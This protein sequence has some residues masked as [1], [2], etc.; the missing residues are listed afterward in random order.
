MC[1]CVC[2]APL[3]TTLRALGGRGQSHVILL[4]GAP[5]GSLGVLN[6][7]LFTEWTAE[8]GPF[9]SKGEPGHGGPGVSCPG[10]RTVN[11]LARTVT[12]PEDEILPNVFIFSLLSRR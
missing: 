8:R 1:V 7:H 6:E 11:S 10:N 12:L 5:L 3:P 4:L 9:G 2:V